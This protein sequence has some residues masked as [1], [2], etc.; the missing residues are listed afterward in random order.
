MNTVDGHGAIEHHWVVPA[1]GKNMKR[2]KSATGFRLK[3]PTGFRQNHEK[4]QIT[5]RI[6]VHRDPGDGA[7]LGGT[8]FVRRIRGKIMK[9]FK[10]PTGFRLTG[11]RGKG[12]NDGT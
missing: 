11:D 2:L 6:Q 12:V 10:S 9:R 8:C 3:L 1:R 7:P 5:D 4:T